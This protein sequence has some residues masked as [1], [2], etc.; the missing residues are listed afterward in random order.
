MRLVEIDDRT[1][2]AAPLVLH[3][4]VE[5]RSYVTRQGRRVNIL[6]GSAYLGLCVVD[7]PNHRTKPCDATIIRSTDSEGFHSQLSFKEK[8]E[9]THVQT[10]MT[11]IPTAT[12]HKSHVKCNQLFTLKHKNCLFLFAGARLLILS[13]C[14]W[15]SHAPGDPW[16]CDLHFFSLIH[17]ILT[18]FCNSFLVGLLLPTQFGLLCAC[19]FEYR[20]ICC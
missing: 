7:F 13:L 8:S 1:S 9:L 11:T 19:I 17:F 3:H 6:L 16:N 15:C 12:Q 10:A 2:A 20:L 18:E 4:N 14:C 5:E